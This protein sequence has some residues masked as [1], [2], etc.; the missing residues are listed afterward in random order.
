MA[1]FCRHQRKAFLQVKTHLM[2]KNGK[3]AGAGTV[4]FLCAFIQ[5]FLHQ[6]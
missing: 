3:R 5:H 4:V 2:A 6:F 1:A